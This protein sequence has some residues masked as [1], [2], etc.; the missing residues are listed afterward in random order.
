MADLLESLADLVRQIDQVHGT[1]ST[2]KMTLRRDERE[3]HVRIGHADK[4][5]VHWGKEERPLTFHTPGKGQTHLHLRR[6]QLQIIS[7]GKEK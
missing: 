7:R 2:V 4:Y 3:S 6:G 5:L 1:T